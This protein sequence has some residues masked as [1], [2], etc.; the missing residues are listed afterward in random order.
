MSK[1]VSNLTNET[2]VAHQGGAMEVDTISKNGASSK[3][4]MMSRG[5]FLRKGSFV[6][7]LFFALCSVFVACS[8]D[9]SEEVE[10]LKKELEAEQNKTATDVT[11][12]GN[13]MIITFSNGTTTTMAI[14]EGLQG[15][16]GPTGPIGPQGPQGEPGNGIASITY[17][18]DTGVLTITMTNGNV[19]NFVISANGGG[20]E[21]VQ[22]PEYVIWNNN[23]YLNGYRKFEYDDKNRIKKMSGHSDNF[24]FTYDGDDLVKIEDEN[25][26]LLAEFVK[27]GNKITVTSERTEYRKEWVCDDPVSKINCRWEEYSE[28]V[29]YSYT[30]DVD[31]DGYPIKYENNSGEIYNFQFQKGNL[32]KFSGEYNGDA[33]EVVYQYDESKSPF[34]HCKTPKWYLVLYMNNYDI[35]NLFYYSLSYDDCADIL[36]GNKNNVTEMTVTANW[37]WDY[38]SD[39]RYIFDSAGYPIRRT[40]LSDGSVY[41]VEFINK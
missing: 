6:F 11:F 35:F 2:A 33:F 18:P 5:N 16:T 10:K 13:N 22:L 21:K 34:Y 37:G 39:F 38:K 8:D 23:N 29:T 12:E 28:T 20:N 30:I 36:F 40:E 19:S 41:T 7:A 25:D 4:Q 9:N 27:S 15:L 1:L 3:S 32:S 26:N 31:N 24:I 17:N 14:P